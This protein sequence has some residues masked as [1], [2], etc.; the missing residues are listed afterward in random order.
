MAVVVS[1]SEKSGGRPSP[2]VRSWRLWNWFHRRFSLSIIV[3]A[4]IDPKKQHIIGL[5]PHGILPLGGMINM[6]TDASNVRALLK[7]LEVRT[8]AAS[9]VFYVPLVSVRTPPLA[10]P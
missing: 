7:D 5:H 8:L 10:C 6:A 4:P 1:S 9:F 2:W 3:D